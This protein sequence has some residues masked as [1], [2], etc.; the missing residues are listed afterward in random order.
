MQMQLWNMAYTEQP[1]YR[2]APRPQYQYQHASHESNHQPYAAEYDYAPEEQSADFDG[3]S[4]PGPHQYPN[5]YDSNG[6]G[7]G[8]EQSHWQGADVSK[9]SARDHYEDKDRKGGGRAMEHS[10]RHRPAEEYAHSDPRTRGQPRSKSRP[11]ERNRYQE[12]DLQG[13]LESFRD[14]K[15]YQQ[16]YPPENGMNNGIVGQGA[17]NYDRFETAYDH[18]TGWD[19]DRQ[20]GNSA[21]G[22]QRYGGPPN[23]MDRRRQDYSGESN[24]NNTQN[25][26]G[27]GSGSTESQDLG[28][29][30]SAH[31]QPPS[32]SSK[33]ENS[34]R[35]KACKYRKFGL[36]CTFCLTNLFDS[37]S[38][39]GTKP[40]VS[41]DTV[42]WDNPF[43][44]F[45]SKPK[46]SAHPGSKSTDGSVAE[47]NLKNEHYGQ[48][49]HNERPHTAS[50]KNSSSTIPQTQGINN[51]IVPSQDYT[52]EPFYRGTRSQGKDRALKQEGPSM[53]G[54]GHSVG[55]KDQLR[56]PIM[57]GRHSEDNRSR[58]PAS[59][60]STLEV[61]HERSMTMPT[62]VSE[63]VMKPPNRP[64]PAV[65]TSWQEPG[66]VAGYYGP[67]DRG[68]TPTSPQ[69]P[70]DYAYRMPHAQMVAGSDESR[71]Y[72]YAAVQNQSSNS[73]QLHT[74]QDSFG[75]VYDNYYESPH[76]GRLLSG[77]PDEGQH[78]NTGGDEMPNFD[79]AADPSS[80][81]RRG[82]TIDKHLQPQNPSRNYPPL[83]LQPTHD[84]RSSQRND[85]SANGSVPRSRSQPN[86][87][88]GRSPR[89]QHDDGF[90]FGV[91]EPSTRPPATAPARDGYGY[92]D[93][94]PPRFF[95]PEDR[96]PH[97]EHY[98]RGQRFPEPRK[99]AEYRNDKW[100]AS[101]SRSGQPS[102]MH[103]TNGP[104]DRFRS[105]PQDRR[106][107]GPPPLTYHDHPQPDR[108]RSPP[109]SGG[110]PRQGPVR[111]STA[112]STGASRNMVKAPLPGGYRNDARSPVAHENHPKDGQIMP[113]SGRPSPHD[114]AGPTSHPPK[115]PTNPDALPAHPAPVRAGLVGDSPVNQAAKPTPVR[116][117]NAT[118]SPMQLSDPSQKPGAS[119][120]PEDKRTSIPV[121]HQELDKLRQ[122]TLRKPDDLAAQLTLAKKLVEAASVLVDERADQRTR[123]KSREKYIFEAHKIVK[124]LSGNGYTEATF[125]LADC[126]TRGALG[127]ESDTREAF[128]LYQTA[129]K[130]GHAQAAYR[131]AVCCEIGQDEGGGTSRDPVKAMQWYK[132]AATLGDT[133][134]M[135]KMG[136]ISLKGLLGQPK[137]PREAIVWLKRAAERADRE[138]PHALHELVSAVAVLKFTLCA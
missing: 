120:P 77:K 118:P 98:Q 58:P 84:S 130:A 134:A 123:S 68:F 80:S 50:S 57:S 41:P 108:F 4:H 132:R 121:T 65:Q 9:H 43:P 11:P 97:K 116:Q 13:Q 138:N 8:Y 12:A 137:N 35:G 55:S 75:D 26:N 133:P 122:A 94:V 111:P 25:M 2:A 6:R 66:Q 7:P 102:A 135:Y 113:P 74:P 46:K 100:N 1:S 52:H 69:R 31:T 85:T 16:Q 34:Q 42:S 115:S 110:L 79:A 136:I 99:E 36:Y 64:R 53:N 93:E 105:P 109:P 24:E 14:P 28:R 40:P 72:G 119:R 29:F 83:P 23:R 96:V 89:Q 32:V 67:E 10:A 3:R 103:Q 104:P 95:N 90:N 18:Q 131:V 127:L 117:Y 129:A 5:T 125:Y 86:M 78:H 15:A 17:D 48:S 49:N 33:S 87:N 91:P 27:S 114:R 30:R 101:S 60:D 62:A 38:K 37:A 124:K 21:D 19:T 56:P 22:K 88:D 59:V 107:Y 81:H 106:P 92:D 54:S 71:P 45:P 63:A 82:F 20:H 39:G 44:N 112:G 126:Y 128:K 47:A 76:Q 70:K 61:D 73:R 51:P